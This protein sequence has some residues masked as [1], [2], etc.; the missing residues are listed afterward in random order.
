MRDRAAHAA[1][2]AAV[3]LALSL[4][5]VAPH[6]SGTDL[7][8]S[9]A[10][11]VFAREHG[12]TPVDLRWYGGTQQF[13]YS[14]WSQWAM[15]LLGVRTT[16]VVSAVVAAAAFALLLRRGDAGRPVRRP[17]LGAVA[18]AACIALNLASG[19]IT[20]ALGLAVALLALVALPRRRPAGLLALLAVTASPV[21]GLFVG[22]V[23]AAL[24]LTGRARD[25]LALAVPTVLGLAVVGGLFG[26]GGTNSMS[27]ADTWTAVLLTVVAG[28]A[29]HRRA[30]RVGAGLLV[31]GLLAA[32]ALSTPVGLN[33]VRLPVMFALPLVLACAPWRLLVLAPTVL[34]MALVRPPVQ[35]YDVRGADLA[36]N[37]PGY[38]APVA[39]E[40]AR[41][42]PTGRVEAVPT[43]DYW[44]SVHLAQVAPLARGWL[45]QQDTLRDPLFFDGSLSP[46]TYQAWLRDTGVQ[47]VALPA[48]PLAFVGKAEGALVRGGLPYLSQVWRG[49]DWVLYEVAGSPS[50]AD[51]AQVLRSTPAEVA[52]RVDAPGEVL[53]RVQPSRW[54]TLSGP[55]CL[56]RDGRWLRLR[57][58]RAGE[59]VVSSALQL[60]P[61]A[62]C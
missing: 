17:A 19:R 23:G 59:F 25:G 21:A 60:R 40:L 39:A 27:W 3:A 5:L 20:Y 37:T 56:A 58:D 49:G 52:L 16:G 32:Y 44:E 29:V 46:A 22:L 61:S 12:L 36:V 2:A 42:R 15:A 53:L 6:L 30:V 38:F 54:L 62:A 34:A 35:L 26:Q 7:S 18:G 13:G 51:G 47:Y 14:L 28:L 11:A 33:A 24:L 9:T 43:V 31:A 41:R 57:A 48:G 4:L 55:G 50:L 45:R 8:A 1:P 10:H